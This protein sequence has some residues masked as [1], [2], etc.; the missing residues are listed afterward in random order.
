MPKSSKMLRYFPNLEYEINNLH[1][2][3]DAKTA[4][5]RTTFLYHEDSTLRKLVKLIFDYLHAIFKVIQ[6][7]FPEDVQVMI[8]VFE[9]MKSELD[10]TLKQNELLKDRILEATLIHDVEKRVL[11]CYE[12]MNDDL[13]VEIEKVKSESKDVQENLVA[14]L[15]N[16]EK[17]KSVTTKFDKPSV[18][19]KLLCVT[20]INKNVVQKKKFILKSEE[21]QVLT[22]LVTSQTSPTKK[23]I[24]AKNN[25]VIAS[26]TYKVD[27]SGVALEM[28]NADYSRPS[29]EG[30]QNTIDLPEGAKVSHLRSDTIR[31]VQN[32][33]GFHGLMFEDPIQH[34]KDF[35]RIV[36]S[37]DLNGATRITTRLRLF[38][39]SL[40]DQAIN[41]LDR[42][43]ERSISTW[44]DLTTRFLLQFFPPR[45]TVK[46][47]KDILM[48]QQHQDESLCNA[49]TLQIFYDHID[50]TT[51]MAID[52]AAGRRLRKLRTGEAWETIKD[53]AQYKEEELNE[54]IFAEKESPNYIDTNLE[55]EL[56]SMERRVESL[57]RS[58]VLLYYEGGF[59][60]PKRPYQEEFEGHILKLIN[61]QEDQIKQLEEDMRKTKD[62]FICLADNLIAT[63]KV[64]IEVQRVHPTK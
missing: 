9:S 43:P 22:K 8:N 47:Q 16:D 33:C 25:N 57:M 32:G 53:L 13:D 10:E 28:Y 64:K 2:L 27:L 34:L 19:Y 44:D 3:L 45:R 49:W 38:C 59:T 60:S 50:Y 24:V 54:Q 41:W 39:F 14:K 51:Q 11:M 7:E 18:S 48:F 55:Q 58:E 52:Y 63:L 4:P 21:K 1:A 12:S 37:I 36:D 23:N 31:L 6:K 26:G 35:L 20:S 17:G 40:R 5:R 15:K 62:T 56:E 46:L 42:L 61:D 29:Q 30:Y